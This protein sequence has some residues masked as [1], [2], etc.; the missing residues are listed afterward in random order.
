[1]LIHSLEE[2]QMKRLVEMHRPAQDA[3]DKFS[4]PQTVFYH[5]DEGFAHL[6]PGSRIL[7][8]RKTEKYVT[9]LPSSYFNH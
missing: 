4:L 9:W 3:A 1:M 5:P 8:D 2:K 6:P 7:H